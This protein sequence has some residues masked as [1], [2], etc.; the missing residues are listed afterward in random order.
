M[1]S[2][3]MIYA[4][5]ES[6]LVPHDIGKQNLNKPYPNKYQKH[7]GCSYSHKL[8]CVD[9]KFSRPF[10]S[11]LGEDTVYNFLNGMVEESKRCTDIMKKHFNKEHVMTKENDED[12]EGSSKCWNCDNDYV[13]GDVKVRDHC[14]ITGKYGSS[15]YRG[16]NIMLNHKI[17]AVF[18]NQKKIW[19]PS[20]YAKTRQIQL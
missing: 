19:F 2:P 15:A 5:F 8:V 3:F 4:D 6:I 7:V 9:G 13:D 20:F 10:K 18:V 11:C 14:H 16:C 17:P 12:F 1:K